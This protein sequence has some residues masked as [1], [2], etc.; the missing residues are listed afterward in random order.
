M[1]SGAVAFTVL[2][3]S[4]NTFSMSVR[5][6]IREVGILKTLGFT[7]LLILRMVLGEAVVIAM[8]GGAIGC[9]P[10]GLLCGVI[11]HAAPAFIPGIKSLA[12]TPLIVFLSLAV[13]LLI[14]L[15]SALP[16]AISA[17]RMSILD[18]LL[19]PDS[20]YC[21]AGYSNTLLFS[22]RLVGARIAAGNIE[23]QV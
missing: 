5:E 4:G 9:S 8:T 6:R 10:V 18:S 15:A 11:R 21:H 19:T 13:A 20:N 22:L 14:G 7:H 2:L 17:S 1:I 16:P 3:V 12:M 23:D